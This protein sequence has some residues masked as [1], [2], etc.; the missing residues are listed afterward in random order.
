MHNNLP[1]DETEKYNFTSQGFI[2]H[3]IGRGGRMVIDRRTINPTTKSIP[4]SDYHQINLNGKVCVKKFKFFDF[5]IEKDASSS[6]R[7]KSCSS[8]AVKASV[9]GNN[10]EEHLTHQICYKM[11]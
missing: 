4:P 10:N 7:L 9:D 2:R 6:F 11:N 1:E 5:D 8:T 3:R